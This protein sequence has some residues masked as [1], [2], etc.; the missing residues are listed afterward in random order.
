M[1]IRG[2]DED[3]PAFRIAFGCADRGVSRGA[4]D[5]RD[6][7]SAD[8]KVTDSSFDKPTNILDCLQVPWF[9]ATRNG[10]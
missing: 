10:R 4:R 8:S 2:L 3:D 1:F 6:R 7:D 9:P 5:L